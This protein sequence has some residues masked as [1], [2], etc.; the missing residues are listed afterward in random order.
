MFHC[1]NDVIVS[2]LGL[3]LD[4]NFSMI[5]EVNSQYEFWINLRTPWWDYDVRFEET[6]RKIPLKPVRDLQSDIYVY[7][8]S[9]FNKYL[10]GHL[11]DTIQTLKTVEDSGIRGNLLC[12][13]DSEVN[14]I[15]HHWDIFGY[16]MGRR[17]AIDTTLQNYRVNK[18]I[19]PTADFISPEV[20]TV[21]ETNSFYAYY[22]AACLVPHIKDWMYEKYTSGVKLDNVPRKLYLSRHKCESR[23]VLNEEEV[24]AF[25]KTRG[26]TIVLGNESLEDHI[27]LF[28]SASVIVGYHGSLFKNIFFS[29]NRPTIVEFHPAYRLDY[30]FVNQNKSCNVT[31]NYRFIPIESRELNA[32]IN[33]KMLENL[34]L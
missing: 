15:N 3:I 19:V 16:P 8:L 23:K 30:S 10:Y 2:D 29:R 4:R 1:L 13:V 7:A 20:V 24:I 18:L 17:T 11:W 9:F 31:D 27:N 33:I 21:D 14:D 28:H 12:N 32:T 25:M 5:P 26:F 6:V 34:N 22:H